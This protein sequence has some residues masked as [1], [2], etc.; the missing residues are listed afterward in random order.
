MPVNNAVDLFHLQTFFPRAFHFALL[1]SL[2]FSSLQAMRE[3]QLSC[4]RNK[5]Y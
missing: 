5:F 3:R 2:I 1:Q 4:L